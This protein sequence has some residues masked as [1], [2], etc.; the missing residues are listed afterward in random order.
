M[1]KDIRYWDLVRWHQLDRLATANHINI[2][3][4]ANV[5][6]RAADADIANVNGYIDAANG[7]VR[8]FKER[9]YLFPIPSAQISLNEN[10]TQ[11]PGWN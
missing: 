2:T 6:N 5:T 4:G 1:D 8:E 3:L 10:L 9:E 7:S 11:N